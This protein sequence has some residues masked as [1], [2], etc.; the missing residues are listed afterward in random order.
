MASQS[1]SLVH[2]V[3][4]EA[5]GQTG[6]PRLL[7][8]MNGRLVMYAPGLVCFEMTGGDGPTS[9]EQ[10]P[11]NVVILLGGLSDGLWPTPYTLPLGKAINA[12]PWKLVQPIISS[13]YMG[14][15]HGTLD[16][17]VKEIDQLIEYYLKICAESEVTFGIIG[18]STG[19]QDICHYLRHGRYRDHVTV[20]VLQAPVSDRELVEDDDPLHQQH[21]AIAQ[22]AQ[23]Q[24]RSGGNFDGYDPLD[25]MMPRNAFW[26]PITIRRWIDLKTVGGA[27]DYFSSDFKDDQLRERLHH[28]TS[29]FRAPAGATIR[30]RQV[31]VVWSGA[32]EYVPNTVDGEALLQRLVQAMRSDQAALAGH[33]S[34]LEETERET[35]TVK[36]LFLAQANHNLSSSG[37]DEFVEAVVKLLQNVAG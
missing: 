19:C 32:D 6:D 22:R 29:M 30:C 10:P 18:H 24:H 14:F 9:A 31:L 23:E 5:H 35:T 27:D 34:A 15:G 7:Q 13:S 8:S 20:A 12:L 17:D 26:A 1:S 16:R 21:V 33:A 2:A 37:S 3:E 36:G 11:K 25:E 28:V 4:G